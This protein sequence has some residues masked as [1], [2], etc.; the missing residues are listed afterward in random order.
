M[1]PGEDGDEEQDDEFCPPENDDEILSGRLN[2][3]VANEVWFFP[4]FFDFPDLRC[5]HSVLSSLGQRLK[6]ATHSHLHPVAF[7]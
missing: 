2:Q 3:T 7:L 4:P 1:E 6:L 5:I